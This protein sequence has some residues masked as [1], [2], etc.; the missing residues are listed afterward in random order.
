M[1]DISARQLSAE[2][3]G[4]RARMERKRVSTINTSCVS[5]L[6]PAQKEDAKVALLLASFVSIPLRDIFDSSIC[7]RKFPTAW[8]KGIVVPIPKTQRPQ[9][10][11]LRLITLLP[12][13]A[14]IMERLVLR[15]TEKH[16]QSIAG[17]NQHG[18]K[19]TTSTTTALIHLLDAAT[20]YYDDRCF[21]GYAILSLDFSS[22]FDR[23]DHETL[24]GKLDSNK[25]PKG[26]ILWL[27]S[28]L[29]G[30]SVQ[31]KVCGHLSTPCYVN[32]GVPQGSVLG[33]SLFCALVGDLPSP[34]GEQTKVQYADDVNFVFGLKTND[35]IV[36]NS[37]IETA[38][39]QI[40]TWCEVNKQKLNR[41]K[42]TLM[43]HMRSKSNDDPCCTVQ[44]ACVPI[45]EQTTI[46]GV[47]LN[48]DLTW[49]SH[50]NKLCKAAASR[51]HILRILR[52]Y[53]QV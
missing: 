4:Q 16:F 15:N 10:D 44:N 41:E 52:K 21:S 37:A 19:K 27:K 24:L 25:F 7:Q 45:Q 11:K 13:P 5:I 6:T 49:D 51:L 53:T 33:P 40:E 29:S 48:A 50:V 20:S 9:L 43:I 30:R 3:S 31:V 46:L 38:I 42:S 1:E 26:L 23:V 28:Y 34:M 22:A 14:K 32:R 47:Q 35:Q 2:L 18:F 36:T 8:K 12:T 17:E 39:H